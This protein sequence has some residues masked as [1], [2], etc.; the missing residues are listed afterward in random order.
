MLLKLCKQIKVKIGSIFTY[1]IALN[2]DLIAIIVRFV[3]GFEISS[4]TSELL[5]LWDAWLT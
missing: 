3:F 1:F 4:L 5:S 2:H